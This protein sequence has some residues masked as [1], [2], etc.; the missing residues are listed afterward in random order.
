MRFIC[1]R[2][3]PFQ[4]FAF[5]ALTVQHWAGEKASTTQQMYQYETVRFALLAC[6][7]ICTQNTAV[8]TTIQP[9]L[10]PIIS[11]PITF[12][13]E[14]CSFFSFKFFFSSTRLKLHFVAVNCWVLCWFAD[15]TPKRRHQQQKYSYP[16]FL[17]G[18][19]LIFQQNKWHILS[20]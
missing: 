16:H 10:A 2:M 9:S 19:S 11:F 8:H 13:V 1:T 5:V 3:P 15:L 6:T 20:H 18:K 7:S 4:H 12:A 17:S 14:N